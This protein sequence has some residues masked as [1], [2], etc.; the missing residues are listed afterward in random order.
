MISPVGIDHRQRVVIVMPVALEEAGRDRDLELR[1]ER[2][3]RDDRGMLGGR[4]GERE[5]RLVLHLA[6][7]AGREN[8]SGG[9]TICAPLPAACSTRAE[10]AAMFSRSSCDEVELERSA[11][12]VHGHARLSR[13][14]RAVTSRFALPYL[15]AQ[16]DLTWQGTSNRGRRLLLVHRGGVPRRDRRDPGRKR[17]YRRH[18]RQPDLQGGVQ[19]HHRPCRGDPRDFRSRHD[20]PMP[21]SSTCSSAP[22]IRPS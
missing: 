10:T 22:T 15:P 6:E 21:K 5:Q 17:L 1:G 12:T 16:G 18:C 14:A 7:I 2:L 9:R 13:T 19:R 3:H 11:A 4:P 8:S 20:P